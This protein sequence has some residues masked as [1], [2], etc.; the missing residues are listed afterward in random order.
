[1]T[2]KTQHMY[3]DVFDAIKTAAMQRNK[4]FAPM[5]VMSDFETGLI[6]AVATAFPTALHKGCYFHFTQ[7]IFRN[8]QQLGLA[9]AYMAQDN[10]RMQVGARAINIVNSA[11]VRI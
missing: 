4:V 9:P 1:M 7:A 3:T 2:S 10:I 8:V 6:P 5:E 11:A